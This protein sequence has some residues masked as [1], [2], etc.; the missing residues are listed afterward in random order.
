M[1]G[2][3]ANLYLSTIA[4][5]ALSFII[6]VILTV[7]VCMLE[8][9]SLPRERLQAGYIMHSSGSIC[10]S[11]SLECFISSFWAINI[12]NCNSNERSETRQS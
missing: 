7:E 5:L 6:C 2:P 10:S 8:R 1:K 4:M 11:C 9:L 12:G 3:Y